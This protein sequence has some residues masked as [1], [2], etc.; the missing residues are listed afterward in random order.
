MFYQEAFAELAQ[1]FA[2][3]NHKSKQTQG[4]QLQATSDAALQEPS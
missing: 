1:H 2:T 4:S 3:L